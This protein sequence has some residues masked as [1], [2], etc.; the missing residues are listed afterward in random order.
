MLDRY[1]LAKTGELRRRG[2]RATSTALDTPARGE[3]AA[4]LRRRAHQL[5]R[6]PQ[7]RDRFWAA[8]RRP[9]S[10]EAFDTLFTVLETL[11]RVAAPLLPLVTERI[12]QG[13]TGGRSVHLDRLAG[14]G[15]VPRA[16]TRSSRAM[17]ARARDRRPSALA[18]RKAR[19]LRVRL[20][21]AR[22]TVVAPD[23][24]ALEPFADILR[25]EL[26]VKAVELVELRA[27]QPRRATASPAGSRVNARA[28]RPAHRQGRAAASSGRRRRATGRRRRRRRRS[29]ASP[30]EPGEY[31]L[32]LEAGRR[33][34]S[35]IAFLPGGG[36]V[37][38]DTARTPELEAEGLAR[39]VVRAVQQ[40]RKAAGLDVSDRITLRARRPTRATRR[41]HRGRH[42][43]LDR[44]A[45]RL[46]TDARRA[47]RG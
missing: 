14:R 22:L 13:L 36:F 1:I 25:D 39:D 11:T 42:R 21:L 5:V 47:R 34:T 24:A 26:N 2:H 40:A 28:A 35:A 4:R 18:L 20:P 30:L 33:R 27:R 3:R 29:A 9:T 10:R 17:D 32:A 45:R 15:R 46:P 16:T 12:W 6:A 23:A 43:E 44:G 19:G 38:L 8:R 7:S 31:E 37:L 41:G